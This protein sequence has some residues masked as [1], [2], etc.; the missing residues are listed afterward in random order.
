MPTPAAVTGDGLVA[1]L[2]YVFAVA[3]R[4]LIG[5]VAAGV[6]CVN[7]EASEGPWDMMIWLP[8]RLS[9]RP[10]VMGIVR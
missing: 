1:F 7:L 9:G 10:Y 4:G 8:D 2:S 6:F 5:L 3:N